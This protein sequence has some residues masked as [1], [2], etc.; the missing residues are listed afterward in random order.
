MNETSE[1]FRKIASFDIG[2]KNMAYCIFKTEPIEDLLPYSIQDW[3]V[4]N[5]ISD[6]EMEQ[7]PECTCCKHNQKKQKKQK[8]QKNKKQ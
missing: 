1:T 7:K 5:L 6:N 4:L 2:I 3:K 8:K